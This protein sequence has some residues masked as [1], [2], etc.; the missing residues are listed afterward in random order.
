MTLVQEDMEDQLVELGVPIH[1]KAP[2]LEEIREH[3]EAGAIPIALISSWQI[4]ESREPHWVVI[5]GFDDHFVYVNDPYVDEELGETELD[6]INTPISIETFY[7]IARYGRRGL[8]A[9]VLIKKH[10]IK[11]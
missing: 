1:E 11:K 5:T 8:R 2:S 4:Y 3:F 7:H 6:S 10:G 9:I